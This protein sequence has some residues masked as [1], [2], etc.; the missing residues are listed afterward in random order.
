MSGKE[1]YSI[2]VVTCLVLPSY[3]IMLI[4]VCLLTIAEPRGRFSQTYT[5]TKLQ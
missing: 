3:D 5:Q 1:K 4:S 2:F